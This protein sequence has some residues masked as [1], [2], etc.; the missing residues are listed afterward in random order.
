MLQA[1][2]AVAIIPI[3]AG[4]PKPHEIRHMDCTY[5]CQPM[6]REAV[7]KAPLPAGLLPPGDASV[8][9]TFASAMQR[10]CE[11]VAL[12]NARKG[13]GAVIE[14]ATVFTISLS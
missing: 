11:E 5:K 4:H 12:L 2:S 1:L 9:F 13:S 10:D 8:G 7:A 6:E 14:S 3:K